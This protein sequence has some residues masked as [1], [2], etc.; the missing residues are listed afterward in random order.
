MAK[1]TTEEQE[2][3]VK[4]FMLGYSNRE[5]AK[6]VLGSTSRKSTVSDFKKRWLA[7]QEGPIG[8]YGADSGHIDHFFLT[9]EKV[10]N[11]L[12]GPEK[13]ETGLEGT[14]EINNCDQP[15]YGVTDET[16]PSPGLLARKGYSPEHGLNHPYPDGFKMGKTT[17]QRGPSGNIERTWERMTEDQE[18]QQEMI[19]EAIEAMKENIPRVKAL[20]APQHVLENLCNQYTITDHHLGMLAWGE[21]SGDDWDINIA[22]KLLLD[23]MGAAVAQAPDAHTGILCNLGDF[24]HFDGLE[25]VTPAHRHVLDADT[26]FTKIVRVAIQ[27]IRKMID[28]LLH[29][30]KHVHV[31][32]VSGNHDLASGVWL[33]EMLAEMYHDEPRITV[34]T[35][36]DVYHYF[37]WGK[38]A[39]FYSHGHKAK[40]G[41]MES[42]FVAKYKKEFGNCSHAYAHC[43]HFH[44]QKVDETNLMVIEQHRTLAAKDAYSSSGGYM[45]GRDAKVITYHKDFGEVSRITINPDM[46]K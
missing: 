44:H 43:G 42:V 5:I 32:M 3:I 21:E 14:R 33:R 36:P 40:M 15:L 31:V 29:K 13:G 18:R 11:P 37:G 30:H 19:R 9:G 41:K 45:S 24:L 26:R 27:L 28:M 38:T 10:R 2:R 22:G 34:D 12:A 7:Q 6:V 20:P 1:L 39:L 4:G 8:L 23:W 46:L 17:I 16:T 25:P 35:N